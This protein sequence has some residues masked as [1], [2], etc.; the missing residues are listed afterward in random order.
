MHFM[1]QDS[2]EVHKWPDSLPPDE[3]AIRKIMAAEGLT[4]YRWSNSP[5]D[6]Y[7]AHSHTFHK[8]IF[9]VKGTITFGLPDTGDRILLHTGDRLDLSAGVSHN[10]I[11]GD[12][13]VVCLEAHR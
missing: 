4:P 3:A 2:I 13:G 6:V 11:V 10:A 8:V 9:V 12:K 1:K 7:G 5:G